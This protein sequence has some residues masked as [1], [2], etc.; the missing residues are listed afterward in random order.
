ML[1]NSVSEMSAI[2]KC[3]LCSCTYINTKKVKHLS[4]QK[5]VLYTKHPL[6]SYLLKMVYKGLTKNQQQ[7]Y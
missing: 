4:L 5:R 2:H 1:V 7:Q 6:I 3:F